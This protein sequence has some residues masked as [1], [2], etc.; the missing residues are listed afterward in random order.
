MTANDSHFHKS[1]FYY[2]SLSTE[3]YQSSAATAT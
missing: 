2:G 1:V 3:N